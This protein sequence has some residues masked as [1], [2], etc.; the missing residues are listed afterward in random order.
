[1]IAIQHKPATPIRR[2]HQAKLIL[3]ATFLI[4]TQLLTACSTQGNPFDEQGQLSYGDLQLVLVE[5]GFDRTYEG[6]VCD[7]SDFQHPFVTLR[8]TCSEESD[9]GCYIGVTLAV[10][11]EDGASWGKSS[12]SQSNSSTDFQPRTLFLKPG[13]TEEITFRP[14]SAVR[15]C[16]SI[17]E[18]V[19]KITVVLRD[20]TGEIK[21]LSAVYKP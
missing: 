19:N 18:A 17:H 15:Q 6:F 8:L 1:M 5:V 14:N 9:G 7:D 12:F 16:W 10:K 13:T 20:E 11:Y 4:L 2:V 3:L 21:N